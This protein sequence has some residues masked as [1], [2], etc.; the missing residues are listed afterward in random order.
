M[1][2]EHEAA[3]AAANRTYAENNPFTLLADHPAAFWLAITTY[4]AN[5]T[6]LIYLAEL[7]EGWRVVWNENYATHTAIRV[8]NDDVTL[9]CC[10]PTPAAAFR[11]ACEAAKEQGT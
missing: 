5:R 2:A 6:T 9:S 11:A 10:G 3:I 1:N 7:P 8:A 4:L